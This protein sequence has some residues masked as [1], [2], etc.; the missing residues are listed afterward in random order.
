MYRKFIKRFFD[1]IISLFLLPIL[2]M[3]IIILTPIIWLD[4]KGPLFYNAQRLGINGKIFNMYKFRS[5]K[6]NSPDIRNVDGST[7]NALNDIR[8]T[9][10]GRI[11][12]ITSIDELPQILNVIKG[13]MSIIGPRPNLPSKSFNIKKLDIKESKRYQVK[14]GITGYCQAYYRNSI[15]QN[16][17]YDYDAYYVDN[18]SFILDVK[19][20]IKTVESVI[21]KQNIYNCNND[22]VEEKMK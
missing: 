15:P 3:F 6:L 13:D 7:Y 14:P 17:K 4:D 1:I 19:I 5:M 18:I 20:L 12:R 16:K 10:V 9:R 11:L 21:K 8:L 22:K 2:L